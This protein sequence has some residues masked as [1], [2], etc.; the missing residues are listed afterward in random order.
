[1]QPH[2][3]D[4][5]QQQRDVLTAKTDCRHA[6]DGDFQRLDETD[7][8]GLFQLVAQLPGGG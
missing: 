5:Q 6:H 2:A 7:D 8:A 1:M 4:A 3:E